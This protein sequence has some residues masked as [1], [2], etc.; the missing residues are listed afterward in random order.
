M[1]R[2][3]SK[4]PEDLCLCPCHLEGLE[5]HSCYEVSCKTLRFEA[6]LKKVTASR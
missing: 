3:E 2:I 6:E 1:S 5:C 4:E